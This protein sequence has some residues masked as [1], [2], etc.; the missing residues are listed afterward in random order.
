MVVM[1]GMFWKLLYLFLKKN[2][3]R[4]VKTIQIFQILIK[5]TIIRMQGKDSSLMSYFS[6]SIAF[7]RTGKYYS[8]QL[9]S[10][11]LYSKAKVF[12]FSSLICAYSVD[13]KI[14]FIQHFSNCA[15][16]LSSAI[17]DKL[18]CMYAQ[19]SSLLHSL[20]YTL[21]ILLSMDL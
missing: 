18:L 10:T 17:E 21:H 6:Q 14:N 4:N 1:F 5:K 20:K 7:V 9:T 11:L 2:N 13:H 3:S 12:K 19:Y 15:L 8:H 16:A